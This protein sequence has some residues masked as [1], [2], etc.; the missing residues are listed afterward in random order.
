LLS[1]HSLCPCPCPCQCSCH[2]LVHPLILGFLSCL[3]LCPVLDMSMFLSCS[4]P[5][6]HSWILVLS[7]SLSCPIMSMF[8]S[9]S[10][11]LIVGFLSQSLSLS[12]ICQCSCPVLVSWKISVA[13]AHLNNLS[14]IGS[15]FIMYMSLFRDIACS[16]KLI[17]FCTLLWWGY[18]RKQNSSFV[19]RVTPII[20][21]PKK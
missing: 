19:K 21:R 3:S 1:C 14:L 2:V 20:Y 7:Q 12:Y 17:I 6:T 16:S 4:C 8:L 9:C 18:V 5:S 13:I 15:E 11:S 10:C